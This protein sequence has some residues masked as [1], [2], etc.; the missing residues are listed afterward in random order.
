MNF[1]ATALFSFADFS[2]DVY[3]SFWFKFSLQINIRRIMFLLWSLIVSRFRIIF[4]AHYG[5]PFVVK[6][7]VNLTNSKSFVKSTWLNLE[8]LKCNQISRQFFIAIF[9]KYVSSSST[10]QQKELWINYHYSKKIAKYWWVIDKREIPRTECVESVYSIP[11]IL[12]QVDSIS[13][14]NCE[15]QNKYEIQFVFQLHNISIHSFSKLYQQYCFGHIAL[16]QLLLPKIIYPIRSFANTSRIILSFIG[17]SVSVVL[18]K[19]R[20]L[21]FQ[22]IWFWDANTSTSLDISFEHAIHLDRFTFTQLKKPANSIMED[23]PVYRRY[24]CEDCG[25]Y[26]DKFENS[27][28]KKCELCEKKLK[29]VWW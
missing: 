18:F 27:R 26:Y 8:K 29:V 14:N 16:R 9:V 24:Y 13:L 17:Q 2:V 12:Y 3:S 1:T 4:L 10:E 20:R 7:V 28:N 15:I 5:S 11:L 21:Q 25:V 6:T 22:F 19:F 23:L